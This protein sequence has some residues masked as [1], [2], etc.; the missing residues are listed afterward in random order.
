MTELH[1]ADP[2][3]WRDWL[4]RNCTTATEVQ[5]V[6]HRQDSPTPS[7]RQDEAVEEALCFGWI[8]SKS[9]KRDGH[10]RYQ[11]FSPRNP[12]SAWSR[13]NRERAER[14][15]AEGRMTH[16][17]QALIDLAKHTGTWTV[18]ADAEN[19]ILPADL[20]TRFDHDPAAFAHYQAFPPSSQSRILAWILTAKR[21]ET[22]QQRIDRTVE[23]AAANIRANH[24]RPAV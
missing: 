3:E 4:T 6:I 10:S 19:R 15:I 21:P 20:R 7:L 22:R 11:R 14:L 2:A 5:L 12:K 16:H 17:G 9:V 1:T 23:L 13:I 18:L 24:P 8:D